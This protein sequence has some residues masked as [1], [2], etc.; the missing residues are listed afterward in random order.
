MG[1]V[2]GI[3]W[4]FGDLGFHHG[5]SYQMS[6][7]SVY[8]LWVI[9]STGASDAC[10]AVMPGRLRGSHKARHEKAACESHEHR[11]PARYHH[12]AGEMGATGSS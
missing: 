7:L 9:L 8:Y 5:S 3:I 4:D 1:K 2:K 11:L 12:P 10:I 6:V